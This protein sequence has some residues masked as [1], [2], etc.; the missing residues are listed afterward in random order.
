MQS[1][2]ALAELLFMLVADARTGVL[3]GLLFIAGANDYTSYRIP[4]WLTFGGTAYALG[5]SILVPFYRDHGFLW[6]LGGLGIGFAAMLPMY[7]LGVMGAGDV[8]LMAM[9]GAFLGVDSV[10][11]ALLASFMVGGIAALGFGLVRRSVWRMLVNVKTIVQTMA[12][13]AMGG[14]SPR[15]AASSIPSIGRL[16]YGV[17]ICVGTSIFL[18]ARQLGYV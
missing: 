4:N 14:I 16:P 10:V 12:F 15:V 7:M 17:S 3:L 2:A 1:L 6:A 13:S 8:K 11:Y 18:V 9:A 5:Y